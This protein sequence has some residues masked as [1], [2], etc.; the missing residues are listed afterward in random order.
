[1]SPIQK[2]LSPLRNILGSDRSP[3]VSAVPS[4]PTIQ[5]PVPERA[6]PR[7]YHVHAITEGPRGGNQIL[8][9]A[10]D[11]ATS[12]GAV[13]IGEPGGPWEFVELPDETALLSSFIRLDDGRYLAGGMSSIGRGALLIGDRTGR[14]WQSVDLDLHPFSA[15][16]ALTRL[17]DG[18]LLAACGKMVTQGKTKAVLFRSTDGGTSW[19]REDLSLPV[20]MFLSFAVDPDGTIYVGTSGDTTPKNFLSADAGKTWQPLPEFPTYKTYKMLK[21]HR[22][23]DRGVARFYLL[24]WGY[25]T[26]IADRV[27]RI[28]VSDP[29]LTR[30]EELPPIDESHFVFSFEVT[31]GNIFYVGSEKGRVYRSTDYGMTWEVAARFETNIGAYAIHQS[32]TGRIWIG[33]DFVSPSEFSLWQLPS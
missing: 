2:V 10:G 14:V 32:E 21:I 30:W 27:V 3:K 8:V 12:I 28:Y 4:T 17:P 20:T 15:I 16:S 13:F 19:V 24:L 9:G 25:K 22:V 6:F 31:R 33:K 18:T 26:E 5:G 29:G 11:P 7:G 23:V 1:M